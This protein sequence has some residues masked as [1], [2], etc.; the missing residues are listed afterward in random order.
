[1]KLREREAKNKEMRKK[2]SADLGFSRGG[3]DFQKI[4]ENFVR[5]FF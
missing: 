2:S 4:F 1:M 3:A 5:P